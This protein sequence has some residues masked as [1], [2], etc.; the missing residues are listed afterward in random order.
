MQ[1]PKDTQHHYNTLSLQT[2]FNDWKNQM[3][4]RTKPV[5]YGKTG[6]V[7]SSS[8]II[9]GYLLSNPIGMGIGLVGLTGSGC[10]I[11]WKRLAHKE[12]NEQDYFNKLV[13]EINRFNI[14]L[15][16]IQS[17]KEIRNHLEKNQNLINNTNN[18]NTVNANIPPIYPIYP[19]YSR[20]LYNY[21]PNKN[22]FPT[23]PEI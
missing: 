2:T 15:K 13:D 18:T 7:S 5:L 19:Q 4:K 16:G 21:S 10:Y 1:L 20:Y 11:L 12:F 3:I 6:C 14:N 23:A 8:L 22:Y 9:G 17:K